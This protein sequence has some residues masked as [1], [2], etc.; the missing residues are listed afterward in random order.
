MRSASA[1][2]AAAFLMLVA[3]PVRAENSSQEDRA[4]HG[5]LRV[6]SASWSEGSPV[7]AAAVLRARSL[8]APLG[9]GSA[10]SRRSTQ[11]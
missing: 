6:T 5:G 10:A 1:V 4:P 2:M 3:L 8:A 9:A 7:S 11:N